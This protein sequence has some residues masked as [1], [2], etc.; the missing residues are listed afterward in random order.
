MQPSGGVA[1]GLVKKGLVFAGRLFLGGGRTCVQPVY[2]APGEPYPAAA[3]AD[4][5][6]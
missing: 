3:L 1:V 6:W 2:Y 4:R 5:R